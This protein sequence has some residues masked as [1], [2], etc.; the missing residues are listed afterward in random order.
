VPATEELEVEA[1]PAGTPCLYLLAAGEVSVSTP[2][3]RERVSEVVAHEGPGSVFGNPQI[4]GEEDV[5]VYHAVGPV[6]AYVWEQPALERLFGEHE[7]LRRQIETRLSLRR[8]GSELVDLLRRTPLFKH[9]S[10][11]LIR[12][13]VESSTLG[14]FEPEDVICRQG[15][16]GDSMFLIVSGE[17]AFYQ[18]D[19]AGPL[20]QLRRGDFFGEIALTQQSIRTATAVAATGSEVLTVGRQAY[21]VVYRRSSTFRHAVRLTAELR[22]AADTAGEPDPELVWL[23]N[24]TVYP[25]ANMA[26]LVASSLKEVVGQVAKPRRLDERQ[27][28]QAMLEAGRRQR[29]AYVLCFSEGTVEGT[30]GREVA[31]AAGAL[32]YF[33]EDPAA[34]FPYQSG[35]P[36]RVHHVVVSEADG[37]PEAL[38]VR[39]DAFRLHALPSEIDGGSLDRLPGDTRG[40]LRRIARAIGHQ[41]VGVALG[42]GAAWGYAHVA[43]L[44]GLERAQIPIDM[45]FGVSMGSMVGAFYASQGLDGLD[46]L[47]DARLE[48]SAAA[49]AAIGTT[50]SVDLFLRRHIPERR[51]EDLALPFATVAVEARTGRET[52]FRHGSLAA[53][54]RASCSLPGVFGRHILGG[55]RYLDAAVRNNV[56]ASYCMEA[57]AD[58]VIACDVVPSP[59]ASR[60]MP[61]EGG[62]RA[63]L[64]ELS[65]VNRVTDTVR[66]LYWLA[67]DSGRR[68]AA[69]A[70]AL[71]AP[72]LPEFYPWDFHRARA[73]IEKTEPQLDEWLAA[74]QARYRALSRTWRTSG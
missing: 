61:S 72:D 48:L 3:D 74:T 36:H 10:Q 62:L 57:D 50:S 12:F 49:L 2:P 16:E 23:V 17:V 21:D 40:T 11:S 27:G 66:S 19:V 24:D 71:F 33:T 47:V 64:L 28:V 42:G 26:A 41:R 73:I 51:L 60:D 70:D 18:D 15:D 54:V 29:A 58:F 46:R 67:S 43:L 31:D 69:V 59:R 39:R 38:A 55:R 1:L 14:W 65:Q 45:I 52:V 7:G 4:T 20:R 34:P 37:S 5:R 6:Q 32:V 9:S 56:P 44:R 13:L 63:L 25:S 68:Q 53:A 8:R 35:S 22:L 30:L